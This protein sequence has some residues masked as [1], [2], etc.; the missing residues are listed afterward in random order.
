MESIASATAMSARSAAP[1][2]H[3]LAAPTAAPSSAASS[4]PPSYFVLGYTSSVDW[5][6]GVITERELRVDRPPTAVATTSEVLTEDSQVR[7]ERAFGAPVHQRYGSLEL[8]YL[9]ATVPGTRRFVCNP[10]LAYVEIVDDAGRPAGPGTRGRVL[11][12]DLNN[13]VMPVIRYDLG[14]VAT[15]SAEGYIGGFRLLDEVLGRSSEVLRLPSGGVIGGTQ[16]GQVLFKAHDF[17]P[18]IHLY[19][20][21]QTTPNQLELRVVWHR[22]P[23]HAEREEIRSAIAAI[24]DPGMRVDVLD[25]EELERLP[26]GKRW[27]VRRLFD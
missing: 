27:I 24:V 11:V 13:Y 25:V 10:F 12:T 3:P 19:Q 5:I 15:E 9:A 14:D 8:P 21:A 4:E 1:P 18:L 2:I 26:S 20:C 7:I 16:L 6:A 22:T 17:T 23:S